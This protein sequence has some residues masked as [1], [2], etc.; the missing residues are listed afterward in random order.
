MVAANS[1]TIGAMASIDPARPLTELPLAQPRMV[2]A[3][4]RNVTLETLR[5]LA[6]PARLEV[7]AHIAARGPLCVCHLHEDLDYTQPTLSKH[8]SVLR[9]AGLVESRREGRWVYYTVN[10]AALDA[11]Y[12]YLEDLKASMHRPHVA[13]HCDE[14]AS[15]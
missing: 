11:A 10:E 5:A 12:G 1:R 9:K 15:S 4:P 3:A 13:D 14:P 7:V 6:H 8:L 2:V